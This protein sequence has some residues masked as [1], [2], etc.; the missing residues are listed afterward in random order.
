VCDA[1]RGPQSTQSVPRLQMAYSAPGPPSS[2][3]PSEATVQV[4]EHN[5][6]P[7]STQSV[8]RPQMAYSAPGPPSSQSPSE[9]T[10]QVSEHGSAVGVCGWC[11]CGRG[12]GGGG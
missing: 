5:R 12:G 10:V 8:P 7:Q 11:K 1:D 4:S 3:S 6:E 9:A 2:Q